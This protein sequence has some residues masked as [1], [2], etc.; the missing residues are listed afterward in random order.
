M[1]DAKLRYEPPRL[2]DM[3]GPVLYGEF[4]TCVMGPNRAL[5]PSCTEYIRCYTGTG[6]ERCDSGN[7]ACGCDSCCQTGSNYR[8]SGGVPWYSG[9]QCQLGG[10]ALLNCNTY[11]Q[12]TGGACATGDSA[13]DSTCVTGSYVVGNMQNCG[14]GS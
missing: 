1:A 4:V 2:V 7:Y 8:S 14:S 3:R 10:Q 12:W 13:G 9:C 5:G 11:G 6:A